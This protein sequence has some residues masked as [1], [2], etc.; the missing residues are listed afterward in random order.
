[1]VHRF[2][3]SLLPIPLASGGCTVHPGTS[4]SPPPRLETLSFCPF[5]QMLLDMVSGKQWPAPSPLHPWAPP[6][7]PD[8]TCKA[9][10]D[11]FLLSCHHTFHS[12][13]ALTS[14]NSTVSPTLEPPVT[15]C[16]PD[17][18]APISTPSPSW[19]NSAGVSSGSFPSELS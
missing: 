3:V 13:Q 19:R 15:S 12:P 17:L 8:S 9:T 2:E 4:L 18:L 11:L 1:M 7:P 16:H 6:S 10:C 5:S 14:L